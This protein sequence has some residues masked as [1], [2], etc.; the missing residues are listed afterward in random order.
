MH[1]AGGLFVHAH[2]FREAPH[3]KEIRL[4]KECE[5][6]I[7]IVNRS[8]KNPL[9]NKKAR[10]YAIL[11]NKPMTEGSDSHKFE[12]VHGGMLFEFN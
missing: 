6:A 8:H 4:Y 1:K 12:D 11:H 7:E 5:D 9:F 10:E 3:I 2:P